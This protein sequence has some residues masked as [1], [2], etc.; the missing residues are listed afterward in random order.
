V[1][2]LEPLFLNYLKDRVAA[3]REVAIDRIPDLVRV[4]GVAW[5]ATLIPRLSEAIAKDPCF[6]FKIAAVYSLKQICF[7]VHG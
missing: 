3:I 1:K 7:S 5:V 4:Y 6:H 2:F